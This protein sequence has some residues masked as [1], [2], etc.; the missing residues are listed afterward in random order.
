M[1]EN[2]PPATL[3]RQNDTHR[4][5]PSKYTLSD[6]SVLARIA[7]NDAHLQSLVE[8]DD[9]TNDRFWA[10]QSLLPGITSR[11][12]VFEVPCYWV[13]NAAFIHAR[14]EGSRF[15]GP[16]RGAWYAAFEVDTAQD[17]VAW[18]RSTE[19]AEIGR[20][21]DVVTYDD[22]LA[23]FSGAF[24]DVR[25]CSD[26]DGVLNPGSYIAAQS[27]AE[28][29]LFAGSLGIVYPSVRRPGGTCLACFRPAL[30]V[31]VRKDKRYRFVWDGAPIPTITCTSTIAG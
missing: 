8:L 18:H 28:R 1:A 6:E 20:F 24:Q 17:E 16:E 3:I 5:I 25:G 11:E 9:A 2:L 15:N 10:E 30:V 26:F 4:L 7:D 27:L 14:P 21:Q 23:D 29:L 19:Y 22:Y 31:N 12:L 13:T